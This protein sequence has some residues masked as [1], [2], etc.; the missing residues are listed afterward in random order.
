MRRQTVLVNKRDNQFQ[1]P[2]D[3]NYFSVFF[4]SD[5]NVLPYDYP[6]QHKN[7]PAGESRYGSMM[8][9]DNDG[10][11]NGPNANN[12][13]GPEDASSRQN[14]QKIAVDTSRADRGREV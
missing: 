11:Q 2:G 10:L 7:M 14:L 13:Y 3:E 12:V 8:F 4:D 6:D 5:N 9:A 1:T